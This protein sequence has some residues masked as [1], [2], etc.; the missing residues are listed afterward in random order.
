VDEIEHELEHMAMRRYD[1]F[2]HLLTPLQ[3][4]EL[5]KYANMV[6][7]VKENAV[8]IHTVPEE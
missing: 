5:M 3:L 4:E 1:T 6:R 8:H 7:Q 2:L